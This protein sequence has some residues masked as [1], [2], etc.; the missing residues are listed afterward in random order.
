MTEVLFMDTFTTNFVL[1]CIAEDEGA[2]RR[3]MILA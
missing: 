1:V 2:S 3:L